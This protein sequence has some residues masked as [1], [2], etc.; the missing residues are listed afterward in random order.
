MC[1]AY[2]L[3]GICRRYI[4]EVRNCKSCG[5]L[6]NVISS[7]RICPDCQRKLEDKFQEVKSFLNQNPYANIEILSK[8][9]D[10]SIKQLKEWVKDERL[11]FA[12]GSMDGVQCEQCGALIRTGRFCDECKM[13]IG[14]N[15]RSAIDM[16]RME[17]SRKRDRERDRM[18]F[19]QN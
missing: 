14:N 13:K 11:V 4:V 5:R 7:K 6:F 15:L 16:P 12:E 18:R 19:L 3:A 2:A 10:V 9:C 8:E 17:E 1:L